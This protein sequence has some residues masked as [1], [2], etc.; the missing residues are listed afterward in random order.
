MPTG[1]TL[2]GYF[3]GA[4]RALVPVPGARQH[5]IAGAYRDTRLLLGVLNICYPDALA[6]R[7]TVDPACQR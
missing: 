7:D 4:H 2:I 3:F 5:A 1:R 6:R